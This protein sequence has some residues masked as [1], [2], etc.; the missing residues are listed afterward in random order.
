VDG[1][2]TGKSRKEEEVV[3]KLLERRK[4]GMN[5]ADFRE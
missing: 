4:R 2:N 1:E 3:S 5:H